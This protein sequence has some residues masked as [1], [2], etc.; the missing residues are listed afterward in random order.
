[1]APRGAVRTQITGRA[2][3]SPSCVGECVRCAGT[4]SSCTS[5]LVI[6]HFDASTVAGSPRDGTSINRGLHT[7]SAAQ[8]K[9]A[10]SSTG[11]GIERRS[12]DQGSRPHQYSETSGVHSSSRAAARRGRSR[13]RWLHRS[14]VIQPLDSYR[15]VESLLSE[16]SSKRIGR[17]RRKAS[18][19]RSHVEI[20]P[21]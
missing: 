16:I 18:R 2:G 13:V 6:C 1:M 9:V 20:E 19:Q 15:V 14:T 5:S 17:P 10:L 8:C 21:R 12:V 4:I 3:C 7:V 11:H